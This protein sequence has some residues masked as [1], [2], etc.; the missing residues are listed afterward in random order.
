MGSLQIIGEGGGSEE[1]GFG[2]LPQ[3]LEYNGFGILT[4]DLEYWHRLGFGILMQRIWNTK[5]GFG[6]LGQDLEY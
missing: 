2:I 4:Q 1:A 3:D 6:I 5:P